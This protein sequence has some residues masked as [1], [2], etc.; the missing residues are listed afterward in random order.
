MTHLIA[1]L[2]SGKGTWGQVNSLIKL[3]QWEKI[4]LICNDFAYETFD[5]KTQKAN[6]IKFDEK[7]PTEE[8]KKLSEY[9]KKE[10]N[11]FEVAMNITS[12]TG[13]EH[14]TIIS[15]ALKAG[16]GIRFIYADFNEIKEFELLNEKYIPEEFNNEL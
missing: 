12:G 14:M 4:H 3:G 9:F 6:K 2:S 16:L 8:F 5:P 11:D 7:K 10:V 13:I 15:A 1:L